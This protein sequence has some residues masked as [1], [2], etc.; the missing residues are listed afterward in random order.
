MSNFT[1]TNELNDGDDVYN[2]DAISEGEYKSTRSTATGE[3]VC[4]FVYSLRYFI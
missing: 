2:D 4:L 3:L 1:R